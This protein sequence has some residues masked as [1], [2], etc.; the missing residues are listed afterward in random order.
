MMLLANSWKAQEHVWDEVPGIF[1]ARQK[2]ILEEIFY[3][4]WKLRR[5]F[6]CTAYVL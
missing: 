4:Y 2:V 5:I 1:W 6:S 3:Q